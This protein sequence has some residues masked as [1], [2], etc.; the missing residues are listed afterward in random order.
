MT[1]SRANVQSESERARAREALDVAV[2]SARDALLA[3]QA[4]EG[5][6]QFELEADCTIP[7]EFILMQHFLGEVDEVLQRKLANY[8]RNRQEKHGGWSLF[9]GGEFNISCSVKSYWALKLVGDDPDAPHMRRVREEILAHGGAARANVFTRITM[10]LFRQIPW[11]GAPVLPVEIVLLPRWFPFHLSKVS[12]WSRTVMVPLAILCSR[13]A[14]ARNPTGLGI[15]ELFVR[16]PEDVQVFHQGGSPLDRLFLMAEWT[17]RLG[18]PFIPSFVRRRALLKAEAWFVE[19]LNGSDGLGAI[20][21]AMVNAYKA[22]D[23]LGYAADHPLRSQAREAIHR[24]LV[25][26]ETSAYCQPCVSPIWDTALAVLA[27]QE[28]RPEDTDEAFEAALDRALEWLARRQV[29]AGPADW[30]AS[31]PDLAPGGWAFQHNNAHYPDLDDTSAVGWAMV[32]NNDGRT[33]ETL[34]RAAD[35]LIGMQSRNGGFAS[36]DA[37]NTCLYLNAIPFADHGALLDPPTADVSARTLLFLQILG[38]SQDRAAAEACL[39]FLF[40]EQEECGAWFGRWGTNYTYGTWSVLAALEHVDDPRKPASVRRA[41]DWFKSVQREDGSWG[42]GNDTYLDP[43][44]AGR[45]EHGT[46]FQTAWALLGLMAA[47]EGDSPEVRHGAEWLVSAR[48]DGGLWNDEAFTAPG[49]PRAFYLRYHGYG[50]YFPLWALARYRREVA[51]QA[52]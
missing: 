16:P 49:F 37:D 27:L 52:S 26:D 41:V 33:G 36:F 21:P 10:A 48:Q 19:R 44:R 8:I 31:R 12:Y 22:L 34:M 39:D 9:P 45:G 11:H 47:G 4:D 42:E 7:A 30:R 35:W 14:A 46:S 13:R 6:W 24:L 38:R 29:T 2:E 20:F 1:E 43:G 3:L 25:V 15:R 50:G 32:Q 40:R 28:A 51:R 18:E 23:L 17:I 5:H